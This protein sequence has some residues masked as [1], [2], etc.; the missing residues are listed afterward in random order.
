MTIM[1]C[2]H[3]AAFKAENADQLVRVKSGQA[4]ASDRTALGGRMK[5]MLDIVLA[6]LG[7]VALAPLC[8]LVGLTV[9]LTSRGPVLYGH[10]RIGLG[11]KVF[12][13][14]KFRTMV[15]DGDAV[16]AAHLAARPEER[17]EWEANRKLKRDP[18]VTRIG[19]VLRAYSVD[20]LPQLLNVLRGEMSLVGPR[21]V[22]RDELQTY[23]GSADLYLQT[24]PGLT[25]PWQISGR[26]DVGYADRILLD[27]EYVRNWS[28]WRDCKIIAWTIPAVIGAR[29]SY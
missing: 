27:S 17:A 20:E 13:C 24:R 15:L 4:V 23:G 9:R 3:E 12:R 18:R 25:G 11:G 14:W 22:V 10:P 28:L 6:G 1:D 5:R 29:G 16:L 19:K 8:L 2:G 26:S 7:L 21:P